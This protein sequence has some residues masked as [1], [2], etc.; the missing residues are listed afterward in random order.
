M[1]KAKARRETRKANPAMEKPVMAP[2]L[3]LRWP[4]T[5]SV[6]VAVG[7]PLVVGFIVVTA[8]DTVA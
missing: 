5:V 2:A 7:D 6:G 3:S 4:E 8:F 1:T